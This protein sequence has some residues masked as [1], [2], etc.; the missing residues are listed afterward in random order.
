MDVADRIVYLENGS[1]AG[2]WT[3]EQFQALPAQRR[4]EMGLRAT[5]L[6][7]ERPAHFAAPMRPLSSRCKTCPCP[8]RSGRFSMRFPCRPRPE[9]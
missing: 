1:I 6:A 2:D 4:Q 5:D 7:Q 9:T 3:P 8:I